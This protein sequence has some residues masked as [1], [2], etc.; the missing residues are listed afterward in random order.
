MEF[1][2]VLI[3]PRQAAM[4]AAGFWR[5]QTIN[6]FMAQA[7]K[8]FPEHEA[9]VAYRSDLTQPIRLTYQAL[10][11]QVDRIARGL[12]AL[13]VG[14][15]DVVSWQL[16]NWWEFIALALACARIGA[17]ANPI[18]PI[19]RQRELKFM[20]DFG[21]AKVMIV[22][23]TY[24]GFDYE[25][26]LNG[27]R[28]DLPFLQHLVV[29]GGESANSFES[30]LQRDH[31]PALNDPGLAPDDVLLLMYTSGTTGEPK[32]VMHTS[33]TLFANLHGF[34]DA[35]CLSQKDV[36]LGASPMAHLTGFGYLAMIPLILNA[37][38]VLQDIWEP[39]QALDLIRAEGIT[40]SMASSP[41]VA[42]LCSAAE[43]G[44]PVSPRFA[45]FCCAGAPIPPVLIERARRVLGLAVSSAWGMTE[46]GAVT[47]TEPT[48]TNEKSGSTDG[49]ALP[50]I[51]LKVVDIDGK[52]LPTG[53]TGSLWVR[54]NSLFG[55]YLKRPHLNA[56]DADGWFDTGDMAFLD[57]DGYVRINGRS[58]DIIIRGGENI[59]VMEVENLLY[60]H[61][62]VAMVAIVGFPDA[63]LGEKACAFV[64]V[65]PGHSF[66][67][68]EMSRYLSENQVTR[69]YHPE[70]LELMEDL[71]KT[72]S[73]KLQKFKLRES[74]KTFAA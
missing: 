58:K 9:V 30:L 70:R 43:A 42:D 28:A 3:Q 40:F 74:A 4:T 66:S 57:A 8:N 64:T 72:P 55:G 13:G 2:P 14:H 12:K 31:A 1:N 52:P 48:R 41:F 63:R 16:P 62:A 37:T 39:K 15:G 36:V 56:T 54:G 49:R 26:M 25:A 32:G 22:P 44:G 71:P 20:L 50:G 45:N 29:L 60:K 73:G 53:H 27:M 34:I 18:M 46:C 33:N 7:L 68:E 51:E 6:H 19:F 11:V 67:L 17:V 24:K 47:I 23:K 5:N 59:P 69:Q 65:K 10:D 61:P 38:T 21:E 35:Y